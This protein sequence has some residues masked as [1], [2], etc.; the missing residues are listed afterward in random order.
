MS[1]PVSHSVNTPKRLLL[2]EMVYLALWL[3][4]C[5]K[6][7]FLIWFMDGLAFPANQCHFAF[8]HPL[9][10]FLWSALLGMTPF[11]ICA[12]CD[13]IKIPSTPNSGCQAVI[14]QMKK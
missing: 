13:R 12:E 6:E 10:C 2:L 5:F 4:W 1:F 11:C 9:V 7:K 3:L 14:A 8:Q